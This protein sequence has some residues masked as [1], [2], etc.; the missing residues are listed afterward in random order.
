MIVTDDVSLEQLRFVVLKAREFFRRYCLAKR[1]NDSY[2]LSSTVRDD[3]HIVDVS[4]G[5]MEIVENVDTSSSFQYPQYDLMYRDVE[6]G[7]YGIR[8]CDFLTWVYGTGVA[9]PR[10]TRTLKK[11]GIPC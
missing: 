2:V 8:K 7:S 10:L 9:E 1:E 6:L 5:K 4:N 3:V 11:Y